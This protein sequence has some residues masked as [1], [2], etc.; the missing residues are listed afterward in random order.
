VGDAGSAG[1][2]PVPAHPGR[3]PLLDAGAAPARPFESPP[4]PPLFRDRRRH[5][6]RVGA[7]RRLLEA[8]FPEKPAPSP[9]VFL[10]GGPG[11]G[12]THLALELSRRVRRRFGAVLYLP[13]RLLPPE[14]GEGLPV[15]GLPVPGQPGAEPDAEPGLPLLAALGRHLGAAPPA[16]G[17][18]ADTLAGCREAL[19]QRCADGVRRLL[20]LDRWERRPGFD[21]LC[22]A[23]LGLPPDVRV[24]LLTRAPPPLVPAAHVALEPLRPEELAQVCGPELE[25]RLEPLRE[26][27]G[28]GQALLALCRQDLLLARLL[29]R[30]PHW[31]P[32]ARLRAA[33]AQPPAAESLAAE[34][35]DGLGA[36]PDAGAAEG[37]E[38]GPD[39]A[40]AGEG[41]A[42]GARALLEALV[43]ATLPGLAPDAVAVLP[44]LALLPWLVHRDVVGEGADLEGPRLEGALGALQQL[45]WADAW[46]G[47]RYW[48]L[49]PRLH[50]L[51]G[52]RLLSIGALARLQP[53]LS[54]VYRRFLAGTAGALREAPAERLRQPL[55]LLAWDEGRAEG[56]PA[57]W[58]RRLHRLALEQGNLAELA[59]LL[60]DAAEWRALERLVRDAAPLTA[61]RELGPVSALLHRAL[62]LA[63]EQQDDPVLQ[64]D[65]LNRIAAPLLDGGRP[66]Q[67]TPLLERALELLRPTAGWAAL[68]ETYRLLSRAYELQGRS[69][70][71]EGLLK[72]AGELAQQLG[73]PTLLA[74]VSV[75]LARLWSRAGAAPPEAEGFLQRQTYYLRQV[76]RPLEVALVR[77]AHAGLLFRAGRRQ[78]AQ[79][80]LEEVLAALRELGQPGEVARTLLRLADCRLA[81][82]DA[83][84]AFALVG[85]AAAGPGAGGAGAGTLEL[86]EQGRLLSEICRAFEHKRQL[87]PALE[88]YLRIREVL[89]RIGDREALIGVLDHIGGLYFQLGEQD[90]S[91]QCYEER[92]HLQATLQPS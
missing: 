21:A 19:Q 60:A 61:L 90:K 48:A 4:A 38:A 53:R 44:V 6:N 63:G 64:A 47:E 3:G 58:V 33:L 49:H 41:T 28:V 31:P 56:L 35:F 59:L 39:G 11:S 69:E 15:R 34:S 84:G 80:Q 23:L 42:P 88:G 50:S 77:R 62:L 54:R 12:K 46:D 2:F 82:G 18:A 26:A 85:Q 9:L 81:A 67:A 65:A 8:L 36:D 92:L 87:Q 51:L 52:R 10:T 75:S 29:K 32:M 13:E 45:G 25:R 91:T 24:L 71:A 16:P 55:A 79:E 30:A 76:G 27:G 17:T 70:A 89:E 86:E 5:F 66:E 40:S 73:D 57:E 1:D 78:A 83:E 7:Q 37:A 68:G 72:S 22:E 20:I 74:Q 43:D 14:P